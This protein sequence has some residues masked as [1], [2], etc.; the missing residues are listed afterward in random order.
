MLRW[1]LLLIAGLLL[2]LA[3]PTQP[4]HAW[5]AEALAPAS[6][7]SFDLLQATV[8]ATP[9]RITLT[10]TPTA[11]APLPSNLPARVPQAVTI[12]RDWEPDPL[13]TG[14]EATV[15]L[16]VTGA[17]AAACVGAPT[18]P[19]DLLL[20]Y[21]SSVSAGRGPGS[22]WEQTLLITRTLFDLLTVPIS[23]DRDSASL[24]RV[25]LVTSQ[26]VVTGTVPSLAQ[27]LTTDATAVRETLTGLEAGGDSNIAAGIRLATTTLTEQRT[28]G[29]TQAIL[30][31]LHDNLPVNQDALTAIQEATAAGLAL[32]VIA[33]NL[34]IIEED[35]QVSEQ[36]LAGVV[37]PERLYSDPQ[38]ADLQRLFLTLTNG[39]ATSAARTVLV[40]DQWEPRGVVR[41][42]GASG[43]GTVVSETQVRWEIPR[44]EKGEVVELSYR[45]A[46]AESAP[47]SSVLL[48]ATSAFI[49]CNGYVH[50]LQAEEDAPLTSAA[51]TTPAPVASRTAT[52]D[53]GRTPAPGTS[54]TAPLPG[55]TGT[56]LPTATPFTPTMTPTEE[57]GGGLPVPPIGGGED[58]QP[59]APPVDGDGG[60]VPVVPPIVPPVG[61]TVAPATGLAGLLATLPSWWWIPLLLLLLFLLALLFMGFWRRRPPP[62]TPPLQP[63]PDEGPFPPLDSTPAWLKA[64]DSTVALAPRVESV[65]SSALQPTVIIGCGP[66]GRVVLA[67]IAE[68]L[69][70][71]FGG[72]IPATVRLLQVDVQL[73]E[74]GNVLAAPAGLGP[75]Q[76]LVLRLNGADLQRT[77]QEHA[78]DPDWSHWKWYQG[79]APTHDRARGRMALFYDLRNGSTGSALWSRI[80]R[81]FSDLPAPKVR[82]VGTTFD[83][84]S[85]GM[86]VDLARL[87]QV[88]T[89]QT[90]DVEFWLAT[91]VGQAWSA[92]LDDPR[93]RLRV[94]EQQARTLATL[95]ELERFQ[96]NA[97]MPFLYAPSS[98][99]QTELRDT[100][101][102]VVQ[103]LFLFETQDS[104]TAPEDGVLV[105]L[106]DSLLALLHREVNSQLVQNLAA[107][108]R[109]AGEKKNRE[110]VGMVSALGS[111]TFRIPGQPL[112]HALTW[113]LVHDLLYDSQVGLLPHARCLSDGQHELLKEDEWDEGVERAALRRRAE[114]IVQRLADS[115]HGLNSPAFRAVLRQE[116]DELLN[117]GGGKETTAARH[118]GLR[119]AC[120]WLEQ[121]GKALKRKQEPA[122]AQRVEHLREELSAWEQWLREQVYPV[123]HQRWQAS[124]QSLEDYRRQTARNWLM[125]EQLEW[126]LYKRSLR[127]WAPLPNEGHDVIRASKRFGWEVS[128]DPQTL[129]WQ[130]RL[131]VPAPDFIW[132][133]NTPT[134]PFAISRGQAAEGLLDP[135]YRIAHP[136]THQASN[137]EMVLDAALALTPHQF[138]DRAAPRLGYEEATASNEMGQIH[139]SALL[140]G[141]E[142]ARARM[143]RLT[144]KLR[145][146]DESLGWSLVATQDE[147]SVTLLRMVDWV[148]LPTVRAYSTEMWNLSPP[149]PHLYVWRAEQIAA[150]LDEG[151][152]LSLDFMRWLAADEEAIRLFARSYLYDLAQPDGKQGWTIPGLGSVSGNSTIQV[153]KSLVESP[154]IALRGLNRRKG[155]EAWTEKVEIREQEMKAERRTILRQARDEKIAPLLHS[156]DAS[157][158]DWGRY[159][160]MLVNSTT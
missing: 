40:V 148:P 153:V 142:S 5:G 133:P 41:L 68:V 73:D 122:V 72:E 6:L 13:I 46:V 104:R 131:L 114:A 144:D 141:P 44:L 32:Y 25:G 33:N 66:A 11:T 42:S 120:S 8:S 64:L 17:D 56:S 9:T 91:N 159:L 65:E 20:V 54:P 18:Q 82:L 26:T 150:T 137:A 79:T 102:G 75:D 88:V 110:G 4:I 106:T 39:D 77:L 124:R 85:S 152:P 94:E 118:N 12:S 50:T 14:Q 27:A 15:T 49:D 31:M 34:F 140:V 143:E 90:L 149:F 157:E 62:E 154:P 22:N 60:E 127:N 99:L 128:A 19:T 16:R 63:T 95:R 23:E 36:L 52:V 126:S 121:V 61:P 125:D 78:N 51:L 130:V 92:R 135:L 55:P 86:L 80:H 97:P 123:S 53:A 132:Q 87:T 160:Q 7:P 28:S 145:A 58:G 76:H 146:V 29:R 108:Q 10:P 129:G 48:R 1:L 138:L 134:R 103:S 74:A 147:S 83:D 136:F 111:Y 100:A 35:L 98:T 93:Q 30:L 70:S 3:Y 155:V 115:S 116:L 151:R 89:N 43:E 117:G 101:G 109:L 139:E 47:V 2:G 107:N 57:A 105:S 67:Q 21:D 69:K 84:T 96:R 81:T 156:A 45:L 112:R 119:R 37:E 113:R 59:P 24:S 71:R 158:R 38:P